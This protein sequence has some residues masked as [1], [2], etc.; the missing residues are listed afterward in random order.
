MV[1]KLQN[2][3]EGIKTDLG[4]SEAPSRAPAR[5]VVVVTDDRRLR[6]ILVAQSDRGSARAR[7]AW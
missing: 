3:L 4:T 2:T 1:E 7:P 5:P 6:G